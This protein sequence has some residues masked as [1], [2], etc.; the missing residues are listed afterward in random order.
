MVLAALVLVAGA[1]ATETSSAPQETMPAAP[2]LLNETLGEPVLTAPPA[3]PAPT[4]PPPEPV[5]SVVYVQS[6][7]PSADAGVPI[8][9]AEPAEPVV[10]IVYV[11]STAPTTVPGVTTTTSTTSTTL[12]PPTDDELA[13]LAL[14]GLADLPEGW[15][16]LAARSNGGTAELYTGLSDA[17]FRWCM[18]PGN[19]EVGPELEWQRTGDLGPDDQR[20]PALRQSVVLAEDQAAAASA[21]AEV[22]HDRFGECT[23]A[24]MAS[25]FDYVIADP[26]QTAYPAGSELG[27][28]E[29]ERRDVPLTDGVDD[30]VV[31]F[32]RVPLSVAETSTVAPLT[33]SPS[34]STPSSVPPTTEPSA[35]PATT[36]P[37]TSDP[38]DDGTTTT[39]TVPE[40]E[41]EPEPEM[42]VE[43]WLVREGRALSTVEF[44]LV[45][46]VV[47]TDD[48]AEFLHA[49]FTPTEQ[50]GDADETDETGAT[51]TTV[52]DGGDDSDDSGEPEEP[53]LFELIAERLA[54]AVTA[55]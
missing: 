29:F 13:R 19:Y 20:F 42:L 43:M 17:L 32:F 1:C 7:A 8:A 45:Q 33:T 11:Q 18:G 47:P 27:E 4:Q 28:I 15:V 48:D 34:D 37:P 21:F 9:P 5:V 54:A 52:G 55:G 2:G 26:E 39:T 22:A 31:W 6:L 12:A 49:E 30:G 38:A 25:V 24:T 10:S 53:S 35:A 36:A 41:P 14:V 3:P 44:R 51:T 40:P 46:D 50:P 16:E 23:A